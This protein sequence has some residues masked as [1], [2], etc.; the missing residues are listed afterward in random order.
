MKRVWWPGTTTAAAGPVHLFRHENGVSTDLG[1]SAAGGFPVPLGLNATGTIVGE[2]ALSAGSAGESLAFRVRGGS[3]VLEAL[4]DLGGDQSTATGVNDL[5]QVVGS[6]TLPA[7]PDTWRAT[8]LSAAD[9]TTLTT[10]SGS[11]GRLAQIRHRRERRRPGARGGL[12][13]DG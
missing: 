4:P 5:E 11:A 6:S 1:T 8:L 9:S 7:A 12:R 10:S 13:R 3:S 2:L